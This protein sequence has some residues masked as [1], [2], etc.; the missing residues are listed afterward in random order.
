MVRQNFHLL[1]ILQ[2]MNIVFETEELF[3]TVC[4]AG[5]ENVSNP[6]GNSKFG[7]KSSAIQNVLIA[8]SGQSVVQFLIHRFDIQEDGIG[9]LRESKE[10]GKI[11]FLS[12]ER[13]RGGIQTAVDSFVLR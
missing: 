2:T 12:G 1:D 8:V 13:L 6:D 4:E 11:G 7:K 10:L 3:F 9:Q 5:N